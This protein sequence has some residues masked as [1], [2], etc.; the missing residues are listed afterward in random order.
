MSVEYLK[1]NKESIKL[2]FFKNDFYLFGKN[3]FSPTR[4]FNFTAINFNKTENCRKKLK[5][6][7]DFFSPLVKKIKPQWK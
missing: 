2:A 4:V 7:E 3:M 6:S 1:R 5:V